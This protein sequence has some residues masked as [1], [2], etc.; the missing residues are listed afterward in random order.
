MA[1]SDTG[2]HPLVLDGVA[3]VVRALDLVCSADLAIVGLNSLA[4][5][6]EVTK[7]LVENLDVSKLSGRIGTL[8]P[9]QVP[10]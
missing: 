1:R 4:Q 10:T 2:L 7:D 8:D 9:H 3:R 5:L 6:E